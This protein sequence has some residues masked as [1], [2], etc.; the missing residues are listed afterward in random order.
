MVHEYHVMTEELDP[1]LHRVARRVGEHCVR[2]VWIATRFLFTSRMLPLLAVVLAHAVRACLG[3]ND[4][5]VIRATQST[6]SLGCNINRLL[7]FRHVTIVSLKRAIGRVRC[8][9]RKRVHH[10]VIPPV[11]GVGTNRLPSLLVLSKCRKIALDGVEGQARVRG[12]DRKVRPGQG[13]PVNNKGQLVH[14]VLLLVSLRHSVPR[15]HHVIVSERAVAGS[16]M[17]RSETRSDDLHFLAVKLVQLTTGGERQVAV[18]Q[19]VHEG[20]P[21]AILLVHQLDV[22]YGNLVRLQHLDRG[23]KEKS[24][25]VHALGSQNHISGVTEDAPI[26]KRRTVQAYDQFGA[27]L[28]K[29]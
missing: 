25:V 11:R 6:V 1:T 22:V 3:D 17:E 20:R 29:P 12:A 4:G 2:V 18:R 28:V 8:R 21:D 7:E 9:P 5:T 27:H 26:R 23:G 15:C 24:V 14:H 10:V 19:R 13:S 16:S